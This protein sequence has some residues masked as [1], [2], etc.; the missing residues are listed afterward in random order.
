MVGV[1][2]LEIPYLHVGTY[3]ITMVRMIT[4]WER[5]LLHTARGVTTPISMLTVHLLQSNSLT[6]GKKTDCSYTFP[7]LQQGLVFLDKNLLSLMNMHYWDCLVK[8]PFASPAFSPCF[9][10]LQLL[11]LRFLSQ[12]CF[13]RRGPSGATRPLWFYVLS[14]IVTWRI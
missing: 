6:A 14:F 10:L 3:I 9:A 1:Y 12:S 7:F 4:S 8:L 5:V 11:S 13:G 2:S